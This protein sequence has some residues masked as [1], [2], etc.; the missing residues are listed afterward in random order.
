MDTQNNAKGGYC[1]GPS[2]SFYERSQ[3]SIEWTSQHGCGNP[4]LLCNIVL[5]YMCSGKQEADPTVQIRDGLTTDTIPEPGDTDAQ[6]KDANGNYIFGMH[7]P[8]DFY[9]ACKN[10]E[11]NKGLFVADRV[12]NGDLNGN[13]A[14]F[15]RQNNNGD[16]HGYECAEERDYYPYW[17]PSPFKD[18][19]VLTDD[20]SLCSFFESESQNTQSKNY[21]KHPTAGKFSSHNN[22]RSCEEDGHIWASEDSYGIAAPECIKNAWQRDNH[23]GNVANLV[24]GITAYYNWTL[25]TRAAE[26]CIADDDCVCVLRLRYN[27]STGDIKNWGTFDDSTT[28]GKASPITEDPNVPVEG[29]NLT[30]AIDTSQF[31]RTFQDRS[32][33]FYLKPRPSGVDGNARIYNFNVR[34]KRGNIVQAYPATEYDFIPNQ[35]WVRPNDYVHFQWTGCDTNPAGNAGEG[36]DQTDRSNVVQISDISK[37]YPASAEWIDSN[38]P[39]FDSAE[40]RERMAFIDQ[41]PAKCLSYAA[42][43]EKNDG[44]ENDIEQD[45]QNCMKLNAASQYFDGGLVKMNST[46]GTFFFMSSRNNNFSNRGQKGTL[47][48]NPLLPTWAIAVLVVGSALFL[49]SGSVAGAMFYAKSHPHSK[50]AEV[51]AKIGKY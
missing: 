35:L 21:C 25:P 37:N 20:T 6:S 14:I 16:R 44:D 28:S 24:G 8:A 41:D 38:T 47:I 10:R 39:L 33:V 43:I 15:T 42:L 17:H 32:H 1:W 22:Q 30:L 4:A 34:G 40:L 11:R 36:T 5:Q 31:G 51:L 3:L 23:L 29:R 50:V 9:S 26:A 18:I 48:I 12:T 27:I 49:G 7:E 13:T 19:A 46:S 45:V 2:M